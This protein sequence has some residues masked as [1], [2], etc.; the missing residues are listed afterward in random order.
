MIRG[1][2]VRNA[3]DSKALKDTGENLKRDDDSVEVCCDENSSQ[4]DDV[5]A[6]WSK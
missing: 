2:K 1:V 6:Q 5:S 3:T 4:I